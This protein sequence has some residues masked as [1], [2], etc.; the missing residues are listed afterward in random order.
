MAVKTTRDAVANHSVACLI[1]DSR[2][3]F[4]ANFFL[5]K[6]LFWEIENDSPFSCFW[7]SQRDEG[8]RLEP[9]AVR[10]AHI[11]RP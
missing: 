8:I 10:F 2:L 4:L 5:F 7:I 1:Y 9:G 11:N 3:G 6:R